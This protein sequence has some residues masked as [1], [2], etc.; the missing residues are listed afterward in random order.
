MLTLAQHLAPWHT[1]P[2][3]CIDFESTGPDPETCMPVEIAVVRFEGGEPVAR[4][5]VLVNPGIPIPAEASAIHGIT[6]DMVMGAPDMREALR[7]VDFA[8]LVAGAWPCGYNGQT[9]DRVILQ[10]FVTS[11]EYAATH[12]DAVWLNPLIVVRHLDKW[13]KGSGRHKL[14]AVCERWG[15]PLEDA[16]R[17]TADAEATGRLLYHHDVR[18]MFGDVTIT[19]LVRRQQVRA[20]EQEAD[21]QAW[22]A[23]QPPREGATP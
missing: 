21:F 9:F 15:I 11:H 14:T 1:L 13:E 23:K 17:A 12:P 18:R 2:I 4:A 8:R 6:D 16:H 10:R 19:E 7:V 3:A 22:L 20:A 5:N